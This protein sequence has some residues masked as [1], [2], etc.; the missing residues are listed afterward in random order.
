[1]AGWDNVD[2]VFDTIRKNEAGDTSSLVH[3]NPQTGQLEV[4]DGKGTAG[5]Q[6]A[7]TIQG[8]RMAGGS[9]ESTAPRLVP[10]ERVNHEW[11]ATDYL[12]ASV[13]D[14]QITIIEGE[15]VPDGVGPTAGTRISGER[16]A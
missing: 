4:I 13:E 6:P 1:M 3:I 2:D 5:T 16:M 11:G 8:E 12:P 10:S 15:I 9:E 14:G 7:T